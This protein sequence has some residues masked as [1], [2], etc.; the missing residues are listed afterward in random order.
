MGGFVTKS[1]KSKTES[2]ELYFQRKDADSP[3][4]WASRTA[5]KHNGKAVHPPLGIGLLDSISVSLDEVEFDEEDKISR[6]AKDVVM[7]VLSHLSLRDLCHVQQVSK[8]WYEVARDNDLWKVVLFRICQEDNW[9]TRAPVLHMDANQ[10]WKKVAREHYMPRKC[11]VCGAVYRTCTNGREACKVHTGER[12]IVNH[13]V[14][15]TGVYWTCCKQKDAAHPGCSQAP[16]RDVDGG[17][18]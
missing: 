4:E 18:R 1:K 10:K 15:G 3:E 5:P 9:V 13:G 17:S 12:D 16:H 8:L 2:D 11:H 14:P 7:M 6:T